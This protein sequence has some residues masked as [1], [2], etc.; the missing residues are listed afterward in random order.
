MGMIN[1]TYTG[2]LLAHAVSIFPY[3]LGSTIFIVPYTLFARGDT[4]AGTV[5]LGLASVQYIVKIPKWRAFHDWFISLGPRSYYNKCTLGGNMKDIKDEKSMLCYHPHGVLSVGY[6]W[7]G[8]HSRELRDKCI[9]LVV[10][11]LL[12]APVFGW[13]LGWCGNIEGAGAQNMTRLMKKGDNI[14]LIPGGFEEATYYAQGI[15]RAYI[16]N[17]KGFIKYALKYGYRIHPVYTF[18][19]CDCYWN[20]TQFMNIRIKLNKYKIPSVVF[21]GNNFIPLLPKSNCELHTFVGDG[22]QFPKVNN[23]DITEKLVNEYHAK[24]VSGLVELF[25]K[26][27]AEVGKKDVILDLK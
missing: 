23:D 24:Y 12:K 5:I 8:C 10:D 25:N 13:M 26:H 18:G 20:W 15:E 3:V 21:W 6:S 22:I 7:N 14:A 1:D 9:F 11:V 27:K 17:R 16:K 4:K 19:E 2:G